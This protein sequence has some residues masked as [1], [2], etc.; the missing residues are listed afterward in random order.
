MAACIQTVDACAFL[1][2]KLFSKAVGMLMSLI[3][4]KVVLYTYTR[5]SVHGG[6]A[7]AEGVCIKT[8]GASATEHVSPMM[9][10]V[11]EGAMDMEGG[12]DAALGLHDIAGAVPGR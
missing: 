5:I 9:D 1:S 3:L 7:Y 6:G 2:I 10:A 8:G 4:S 12:L 11:A